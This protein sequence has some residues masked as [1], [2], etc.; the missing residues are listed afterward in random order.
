MTYRC[1]PGGL[2]HEPAGVRWSALPERKVL[3][4]S[5]GHG[6]IADQSS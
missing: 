5:F 2:S 1:G 3:K 6:L 4:D